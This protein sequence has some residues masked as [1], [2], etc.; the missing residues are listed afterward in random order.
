[1]VYS[2][3]KFIVEDLTE[4]G[5]DA[6]FLSTL[7]N[8]MNATNMMPDI[9]L[10]PAMMKLITKA[11]NATTQDPLPSGPSVLTTFL[12]VRAHF[13]GVPLRKKKYF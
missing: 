4:K 9:L 7:N 6:L 10:S 2:P 1:M 8:S 5:I 11:A 13:E 3:S 12:L